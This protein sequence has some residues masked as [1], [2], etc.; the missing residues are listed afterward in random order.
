MNDPTPV[1]ADTITTEQIH[2]VRKALMG[3]PRKNA[4]HRAIIADCNGAL[5]GSR[6]CRESVARAYNKMLG[7]PKEVERG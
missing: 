3:M 2:V 6:A 5:N 4:H 7:P 1:S